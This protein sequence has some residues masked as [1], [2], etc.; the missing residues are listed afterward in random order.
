[1]GASKQA[2]CAWKKKRGMA[3]SATAAASPATLPR[4]CVP[5][6]YTSAIAPPAST[7]AGKR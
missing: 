5:H 4:A 2:R 6:T 7:M 1:M 3:A